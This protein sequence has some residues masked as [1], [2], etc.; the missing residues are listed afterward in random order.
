MQE[1]NL[2]I[3]VDGSG[4]IVIDQTAAKI[5]TMGEQG[6]ASA[7]E[8]ETAFNRVKGVMLG[9]VAVGVMSKLGGEVIE[10][11]EHLGSIGRQGNLAKAEIEALKEALFDIS[12]ATFQ[13]PEELL[14][15]ISKIMAKT[16]DISLAVNNLRAIGTVASASGASVEDLA[17]IVADLSQKF[18]VAGADMFQAL[19]ILY[20]QGKAGAFELKDLATQGERL[21]A[22][23]KMMN[24]TGIEGV[25]VMG[26]MVQVIRQATGSAEEATTSFENLAREMIQ[27]ADKIKAISGV[28][29]LDS[30]GD[31]RRMDKVMREIVES[32]DGDI[33]KLY[34][35][36][37]G[38]AMRAVNAFAI[39][40]KNAGK[41]WG[42]L[43]KF[44][45]AGGDL[46]ESL[47]DA[48]NR[49]EEFSARMTNVKTTLLE[50][51]DAFGPVMDGGSTVLVFLAQTAL[52]SAAGVLQLAI[53]WETLG[54]KIG[55]TQSVRDA[56]QENIDA[57][58]LM[59]DDL[60][61]KVAGLDAKT[62]DYGKTLAIAEA[63]QKKMNQ[64][65]KDGAKAAADYTKSLEDTRKA[66]N[67]MLVDQYSKT[68]DQYEKYVAAGADKLQVDK[69]YYGELSR[70][71]DTE[72]NTEIAKLRKVYDEKKRLLD[73]S[74]KDA[75]G[76]ADILYSYNP[77]KYAGKAAN[78]SL[79]Q[80]ASD[81]ST[82]RQLE[83]LT[84]ATEKQDFAL[85]QALKVVKQYYPE[86]KQ[87][88]SEATVKMNELATA[89]NNFY[90]DYTK[91]T[92]DL[93][94]DFQDKV[95]DK[96]KAIQQRLTD[97]TA[98]PWTIQ[99]LM[100]MTNTPSGLVTPAA[101]TGGAPPATPQYADGIDYVPED[102]YAFIHKGEAV[103]TADENAARGFGG[104]LGSSGM[105]ASGSFSIGEMHFHVDGTSILSSPAAQRDFVRQ[106]VVPELLKVAGR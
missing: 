44:I 11:D 9:L 17:A 45:K 99:V 103:L 48:A 71:A 36:F 51:A 89:F 87:G 79:Q 18:Q 75:A 62:G 53:A 92:A 32:V 15:G 67:D 57:L 39:S 50:V 47:K 64:Q 96:L 70:L 34:E 5:R 4:N 82:R 20:V 42:E 73:Q 24:L 93:K 21:T 81:D 37:S 58:K 22:S 98:H 14:K 61:K 29:V 97:L 105:P 86:L 13:G 41:G 80:A 52:L 19:D 31:P 38:R 76:A 30:A 78:A 56:H 65:V 26:G 101:D 102:Q 74:I 77:Q 83:G 59:Q 35:M 104:I 12:K 49:S 27:N 33:T 90:D 91:K 94:M 95:T 55:I 100:A 68:K 7:G 25:R 46:S 16:G 85:A 69:W 3:A 43:D 54:T 6:K 63:A 23:A 1:I 66:F 10:L 2:R 84:D 72:A 106:A 28:M 60:Y 40:W 8:L 88:S